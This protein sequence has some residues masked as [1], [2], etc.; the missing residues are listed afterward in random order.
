[1][2]MIPHFINERRLRVY[3]RLVLLAVCGVQAFNILFRQGWRGGLG[4]IIGLDF[5]ILYTGGLLYRTDIAHLYDY[6]TQLAAERLLIRP[7]A[8]PGSGPFSNPPFVAW[9]Y[10]S[11]THL[12]LVWALLLWSV[13]ILFFLFLAADLSVRYLTPPWLVKAGLTRSRLTIVLL[14]FWPFFGGFH[15]GQ[16]HG[17]TFLLATAITVASVTGR[18]YLA[19]AS[20]GLLMYKPQFVLGFLFIWLI[21]SEYKALASYIAVTVLW[22]GV[23]VISHGFN[24]FVAYLSTIDQILWLPFAEGWPAYLMSTPYGLLVTL[25][26]QQL[27]PAILW[28]TRLLTV[29]AS[30]G[31]AWFAYRCRNASSSNRRPATVF[32]LLF[33]F[34]ATPYVLYHD[35]LI[36]VPVFLLLL[37]DR[38]EV[39]HLLYAAI[40]T[41]FGV[42]ALLLLGQKFN[43]ALFVLIPAGLLALQLKSLRTKRIRRTDGLPGQ[44]DEECDSGLP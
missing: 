22:A 21:W 42:L 17:L 12:P 27:L 13:L 14:S 9:A 8:L 25:L 40:F 7:T 26:P 28:F 32:A 19:G 20:A 29:A 1:M 30:V 15:A 37:A 23:V 35:L 10:S 41:Y 18:W 38:E 24:P 4:Q 3:P 31:I 6:P 39:G 44:G 16:N 5:I 33:P 2:S 34:L 11:F 43:V 36:L